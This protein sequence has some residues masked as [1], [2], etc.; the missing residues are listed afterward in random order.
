MLP[1]LEQIPFSDITGFGINAKFCKTGY[2]VG[3][4]ILFFGFRRLASILK[5]FCDF[6]LPDLESM[7]F[8]VIN[9]NDMQNG[10]NSILHK[11]FHKALCSIDIFFL[12][13]P[14][15]NPTDDKKR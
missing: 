7:P 4:K 9:K 12:G 11:A 2:S 8:S 3:K 14:K 15:K 5:K 13:H 6:S 1:I 10:T